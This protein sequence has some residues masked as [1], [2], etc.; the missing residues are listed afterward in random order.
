MESR[1]FLRVDFCTVGFPRK[2]STGRSYG[3]RN[4]STFG[5]AL[6]LRQ[7]FSVGI[8]AECSRAALSRRGGSRKKRESVAALPRYGC[9]KASESVRF[10]LT[11]A[12]HFPA[13][14][15][16]AMSENQQVHATND[17]ATGSAWNLV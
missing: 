16:I 3:S 12:T 10:G 7:L 17:Y 1:V 6:C 11:P 13:G 15:T 4:G 5:N 2:F 9:A 8:E 14:H